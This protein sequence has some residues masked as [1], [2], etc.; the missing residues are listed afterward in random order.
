MP[1]RIDPG[2]VDTPLPARIAGAITSITRGMCVVSAAIA[3]LLPLPVVYG[4][5]MDQLQQPPTWVFETTGYAIIMIA[6]V[7]SGY[8]LNT[9]HHFRVSLLAE[10][11]SWRR[12][13]QRLSGLVEFCFGLVLVIAGSQQV[14]N[15]YTQNLTSD[16]LLAVPQF[17]PQLAFPI[18][19]VAIALQGIAH[20]LH[21][22]TSQLH[23]VVRR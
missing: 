8:G 22:H 1:Y 3:I 4:V 18:G 23:D 11:P 5:I 15:A 7:A 6:F 2:S 16:T 10:I 21:P 13:L 20:I 12:G 9:G 19:G 17:L 14:Y